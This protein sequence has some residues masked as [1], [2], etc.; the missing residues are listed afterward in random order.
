MVSW[1]SIQMAGLPPMPALCRYSLVFMNLTG[2][3]R[4]WDKCWVQ[5]STA[6]AQ[7]GARR[8]TA[9]VPA[10]LAVEDSAQFGG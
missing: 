6:G 8:S 5:L 10:A 1:C 2:R 7:L 4:C 3:D 9:A